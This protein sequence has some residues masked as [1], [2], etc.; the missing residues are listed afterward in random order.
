MQALCVTSLLV[1]KQVH[2]AFLLALVLASLSGQA[3]MRTLKVTLL[4]GKTNQTPV[5]GASIYLRVPFNDGSYRTF[6]P[7]TNAQGNFEVYLNPGQD[8]TAVVFDEISQVQNNGQG[9]IQY[10]VREVDVE[11]LIVYVDAEVDESKKIPPAK[12]KKILPKE[13]KTKPQLFTVTVSG[14]DGISVDN[15]LLRMNEGSWVNLDK[16]GKTT[17]KIKQIDLNSTFRVAQEG[18]EK[19]S[20]E[21]IHESRLNRQDSLS[22]QSFWR[23]ENNGN[24]IV[25]TLKP[26][27]E[28]PENPDDKDTIRNVLEEGTEK[29]KALKDDFNA[30]L[31]TFERKLDTLKTRKFVDRKALNQL[32]QDF[33]SYRQKMQKEIRRITNAMII[34]LIPDNDSLRQKLLQEPI[35]TVLSFLNRKREEIQQLKEAQAIQ[36]RRSNQTILTISIAGALII[37]LVIM[38]YLRRLRVSNRNLASQNTLINLL[39]GEVNHRVKNNL[40]SISSKLRNSHLKA[41]NE[42][43]KTTLEELIEFTSKLSQLQAKLDFT[44]FSTDQK[45]L[46]GFQIERDLEDMVNTVVGTSLLNPKPSIQIHTD[47]NG[48]RND[49]FSII[50]FCAFELAN[51]ICKYAFSN[52]EAVPRQMNIVLTKRG[53]YICLQLQDNGKGMPV[54]L[55]DTQGKFNFE[56]LNSSKGL[57]IIHHLTILQKGNF[58]IKTAKIHQEPNQGA[59]FECNFKF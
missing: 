55:F 25:I 45:M 35:D 4:V 22:S 17:L 13:D 2:I 5:S 21:V 34:T 12:E 42:A 32:A 39:I 52:S 38:W 51:N 59:Y 50:G 40:F 30:Q 11:R 8:L 27:I 9:N 29:I 44:F 26:R 41:Q 47:L 48:L 36:K 58:V 19:E 46:H 53:S 1:Y 3:Q 6:N 20:F 28:P 16:A 18:H 7:S 43:A 37:F 10:K 24:L 15:A 14:L 33:A 56:Q 31:D 23:M 57:R 49:Y 54:E